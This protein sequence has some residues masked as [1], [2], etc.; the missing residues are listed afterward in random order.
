M[1]FLNQSPTQLNASESASVPKR[2]AVIAGG[3]DFPK[4]IARAAR[5]VG[6]EVYVLALRGFADNDLEQLATQLEWLELGQLNRAIELLHSLGIEYL[7]LAGRVPHTTI[8]QY[9]HFDWR[10]LKLLT[11]AVN[12]KA[13]TLLGLLSD[14]FEREGIHVLDS[15]LFLKSLMPLPGLLTPRRPLTETE[16][17]D[18]EFGFPIAKLIAGQDIGQTIVV[19]EKMVIAVEAAEGTDECILRA[20]ALAGPGCIVV[21]VSKPNQDFRFDIPVIGKK[22]IETMEKAG[23]RAIGVSAGECLIFDQEEVI[24]L[25]E[26]KGIGIVAR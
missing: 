1:S 21:K 11:R 25:A 10:A 14:E 4:L 19:K 16:Q 15:S 13:D 2:I 17:S 9:R 8:F 18:L 6:T 7:I 23:A 26:K 24:A 3:G 12:K 5:G 20:G 22:T